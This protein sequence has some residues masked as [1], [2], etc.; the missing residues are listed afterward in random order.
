MGVVTKNFLALFMGFIIHCEAS[1]YRLEEY[2]SASMA[3]PIINP[4]FSKF[5]ISNTFRVIIPAKDAEN[6]NPLRKDRNNNFRD[7]FI[8][9]TVLT[10]G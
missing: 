10:F 4:A 8:A 7:G 6:K 1:I 2:I 9:T 3:M 5:T